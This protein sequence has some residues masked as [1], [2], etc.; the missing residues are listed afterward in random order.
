MVTAFRKADRLRQKRED[1][2][3]WLQ[4]RYIYDALG[5][6]S[7]IL[8]AFAKKG[9]KAEPYLDRP[10]LDQAEEPD[11]ENMTEDQRALYEENQLKKE[12]IRMLN[13][14]LAGA[15]WGK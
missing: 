11:P 10:Y 5:R 8:H 13:L 12:R 2:Q 14:R 6:L 9:A 1:A 4:G 15:N 3:A 7:P